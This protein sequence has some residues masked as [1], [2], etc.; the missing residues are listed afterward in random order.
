MQPAGEIYKRARRRGSWHWSTAEEHATVNAV[1][2]IAAGPMLALPMQLWAEAQDRD[3]RAAGRHLVGTDGDITLGIG[4]ASASISSRRYRRPVRHLVRRVRSHADRL[5]RRSHYGRPRLQAV[6]RA[7]ATKSCPVC[8]WTLLI[9]C[10]V[11]WPWPWHHRQ[12]HRHE[13]RVHCRQATLKPPH[14]RAVPRG[15]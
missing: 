6:A 10:I 4:N 14:C 15:R 13:L 2:Q 1:R 9:S 11:K 7:H 8:G 5:M 3:K 12:R